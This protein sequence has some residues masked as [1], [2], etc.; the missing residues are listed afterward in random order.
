VATAIFRFDQSEAYRLSDRLSAAG[1]IVS[2]YKK[3]FGKKV[4]KGTRAA[5]RSARVGLH[6]KENDRC[7]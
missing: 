3:R 1:Q 4:T 5:D 2:A 7:G 6:I